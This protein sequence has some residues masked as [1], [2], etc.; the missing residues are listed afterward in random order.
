MKQVPCPLLANEILL[1]VDKKKIT[2]V[3]IDKR[4]TTISLAFLNIN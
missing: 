3:L 2:I 4:F 1:F